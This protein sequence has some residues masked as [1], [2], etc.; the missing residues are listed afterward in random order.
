M[1]NGWISVRDTVLESPNNNF[2]IRREFSDKFQTV[3]PFYMLHGADVM[4]VFR[5]LPAKFVDEDGSCKLSPFRLSDMERDFGPWIYCAVLANIGG[6]NGVT[7]LLGNRQ[8]DDEFTIREKP[9]YVLFSNVRRLL[10]NHVVPHWRKYN[11][12]S[13]FCL[14]ETAVPM[15]SKPEAHYFSFG[16]AVH[17]PFY[18]FNN[19]FY[20][21]KENEKLFIIVMRRNLGD[22]L[23]SLLD[24]GS[25]KNIDIIDLDSGKH[26][27]IYKSQ[28]PH[29]RGFDVSIKDQFNGMSPSLKEFKEIVI[30]KLGWWDVLHFPTVEEQIK[31]ICQSPLP[32]EVVYRALR[33]RFGDLLPEETIE[34]AKFQEKH[35]D[36]DPELKEVDDFRQIWETPTLEGY[37]NPEIGGINFGTEIDED[38]KRRLGLENT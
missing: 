2:V 27:L 10:Y 3:W 32:A 12:I 31:Y 5:F 21:L 24:I 9:Y 22:R 29:Y 23:M 6:R 30:N 11:L 13:G 1:R 8:T 37:S 17:H 20:G 18:Q 4:N 19:Q 15:L 34:E 25:M 26:V 28:D 16:L 33:D 38:I 36:L 14:D 35:K 7:F